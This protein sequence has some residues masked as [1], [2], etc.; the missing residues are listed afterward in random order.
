MFVSIYRDTGT[1]EIEIVCE[2]A[3][4]PGSKPSGPRGE[5]PTDPGS[6]PEIE[7]MGAVD[8]STGDEVQLTP[9]EM[10]KFHDA[11]CEAASE[12]I[13]TDDEADYHR[14][15]AADAAYDRSI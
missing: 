12:A 10:D 11:A 15:R 4:Y 7:F 6:D 3:A 9:A 2:F 5:P 13:S 14:D 8:K 1:D